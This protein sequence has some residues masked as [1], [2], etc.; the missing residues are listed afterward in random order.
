MNILGVNFKDKKK[1]AMKFLN[2]LGNPYVYLAKDYLG[3]QSINFGIYG[4]PETILVNSEFTILKN[5]L[6]HFQKVTSRK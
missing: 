6:G 5:I 4:I 3:K 1:N 2:D